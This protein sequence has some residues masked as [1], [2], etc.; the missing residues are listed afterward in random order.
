MDTMTPNTPKVT[1]LMPVY[2]VAQ[3]VGEAIGSILDQTYSDFELLV[4]NDG[5][6]DATREKVLSFT[7][8]RI[9]FVENERNIGLANTLN[10]GIEL[11]HGEYIARMDGDDISVPER[12][13][14]QVAVLDRH[15]EIAICGAGYRFFGA[16]NYA[17]IYP[18]RDAAIKAGLLFGCCM[19]IPLFR[20]EAILQSGLRYNQNYFPAEDYHFWTQ[21][22]LKGLQMYN[23]PE[24]LFH[25]RM[26][27]SQ[28]SEVMS[29]QPAMTIHV[30]T[31]YFQVLFP[32]ADNQLTTQFISDLNVPIKQ[33]E[34]FRQHEAIVDLLIAV[35][36]QQQSLSSVAL[37]VL[38]NNHLASQLACF[39]NDYWFSL[40]YSFK[41]LMRLCFAGLYCR[42]PFKF[43]NKLIIKCLIRKPLNH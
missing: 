24:I 21:C 16:R 7:D 20:R 18:E 8:S 17:A 29:N 31:L 23:I 2:N 12:L 26:H 41:G 28:V 33:T 34:D 40:H 25:Y 35:N 5:S 22:A 30:R 19:I 13:E 27:E 38:L 39:V 4:I 36:K 1:V 14:K 15:A 3:Y 43:R 32:T 6:T 9:R 37:T 10:R 42:L 11:A